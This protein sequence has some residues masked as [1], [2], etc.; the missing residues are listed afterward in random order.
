MYNYKQKQTILL[1]KCHGGVLPWISKLH[2]PWTCCYTTTV[3]KILQY[4]WRYRE[5]WN[6]RWHKPSRQI[7]FKTA[8]N[9]NIHFGCRWWIHLEVL[10]FG[11]YENSYLPP[12]WKWAIVQ[13]FMCIL[14]TKF[15]HI[16][17]IW[18]KSFCS[19]LYVSFWFLT[20]ELSC[21]CFQ[22]LKK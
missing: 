8:A 18:T 6:L 4:H 12:N 10:L 14:V 11:D 21:V 19:A 15:Q 17:S 13:C 1:W 3:Y 7:L 5:K 2:F 20:S 22:K 16:Q 9:S